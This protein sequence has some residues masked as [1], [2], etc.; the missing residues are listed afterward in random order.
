MINGQGISDKEYKTL[1]ELNKY[2]SELSKKL[3]EI[4]SGIYKGEMGF[5][6]VRAAFAITEVNAANDIFTDMENVEKSFEGYPSS[7]T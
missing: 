7:C 6:K 4:K 5:E 2:A 1:N 3:D